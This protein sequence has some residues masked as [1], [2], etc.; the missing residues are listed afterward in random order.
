MFGALIGLLL[1]SY[2]G[3]WRRMEFGGKEAGVWW[4]EDT[5]DR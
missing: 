5:R 2:T 3:F 4:A 1:G